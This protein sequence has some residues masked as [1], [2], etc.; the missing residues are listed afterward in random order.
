MFN[1]NNSDE[2]YV[3]ATHIEMGGRSVPSNF[4]K[5][6]SKTE[7]HKFKGKGKGKKIVTVK[8][9]GER[10]TCTHCK[11]DGHEESKCWKLHL[12]LRPKKFQKKGKRKTTAIVQQDLGSD[13][14]DETK[15]IVMGHKGN[16]SEASTSS[17]NHS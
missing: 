11:K 7:D 2:V 12:E 1:P 15:I 6:F 16:L 8:K 3:Q 4:Q 5:K 10:P 14:G 9:E 13:S 17:C